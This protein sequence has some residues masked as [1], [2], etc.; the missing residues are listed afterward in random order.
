MF[1]LILPGTALSNG[2]MTNENEIGR[3]RAE[4]DEIDVSVHDKLMRRV[5]LAEEMAVA[6]DIVAAGQA[7]MRPGREATILRDLFARHQGPL[8][9][10]VVARIWREL[11]NAN[12]R[13][14]GDFAIALFSNGDDTINGNARSQYGDLTPLQDCA[15]P[16]GALDMAAQ[17]RD[18]LAVLPFGDGH[19][20]WALLAR[21][22]NKNL[23]VIACLPFVMD[24][25]DGITAISVGALDREETGE[26]VSLA[27]V[28][29]SSPDT[30]PPSVNIVARSGN[31]LLIAVDDYCTDDDARWKAMLNFQGVVSVAP[32]GGYAKPI[33]LDQE[34]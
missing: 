4:I 1:S 30:N 25:D 21:E 18:T 7:R 12:L 8:G 29:C 14:E 16:Q 32:I 31:L 13:V 22:N 5:A 27:V 3:I 20:S 11:I 28:S 10:P 9:F 34:A 24:K 19:D 23:K 33:I 15:S 17:N 26:D 6:K 2:G